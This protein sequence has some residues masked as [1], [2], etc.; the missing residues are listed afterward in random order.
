MRDMRQLTAFQG[1]LNQRVRYIHRRGVESL[2]DAGHRHRIDASVMDGVQHGSLKL[3]VLGEQAQQIIAA[4]SCGLAASAAPRSF[5]IMF[6]K[7]ASASRMAIY[8]L[9]QILFQPV[10]R[11]AQQVVLVGQVFHALVEVGPERPRLGAY[12]P[13]RDSKIRRRA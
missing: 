13:A 7:V 6:C 10:V 9:D 1:T 2:A 3:A 5:L 4:A 8:L 12:V 11:K